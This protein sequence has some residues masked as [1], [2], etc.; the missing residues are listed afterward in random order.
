[1]ILLETEYERE[2]TLEDGVAEHIA[3]SSGGDVRKAMNALEAL[4][5]AS[6][7]EPGDGETVCIM[8]SDALLV[9]QRSANRFD[10][11]GDSHYDLLSAFQKS[12]R[13]SDP[14]A[15]LHYL[16]RI[17][18]GGDMISAIRRLIVTAA[19]DV[20]LA[21]P[22]AMPIV[23]ACV[24]AA[25]HVGLPEAQIPL[26]EAVLL[27]ATAPKSNSAAEA[28]G[29]AMSDVKN[30]KIGDIPLHL[31]DSHYAGAAKLGHGVTYKYPH[32][33]PNNYVAQ[34]YL[35]DALA[36]AVYYKEGSNKNELASRRYWEEIKEKND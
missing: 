26:S 35:P 10:R 18:E 2:I 3:A 33:F 34:Q 17:L 23:M 20:G 9:S 22:Q 12:I 16:A 28:I 30:G 4:A 11:D 27:C 8:L 29:A 6:C 21:Y 14:N 25:E 19:E 36:G 7:A 24:E 1:L 13:G 15:A 5:A 32:A 31:K